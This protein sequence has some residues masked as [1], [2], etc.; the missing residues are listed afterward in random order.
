MHAAYHHERKAV[1][2]KRKKAEYDMRQLSH[3]FCFKNT[4]IDLPGNS[5]AERIGF[6]KLSDSTV[7]K[8]SIY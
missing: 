6:N 1:N 7:C 5:S 8:K 3:N 2:Q 4:N